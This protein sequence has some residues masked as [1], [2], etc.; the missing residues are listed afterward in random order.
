M[1]VGERWKAIQKFWSKFGLPAYDEGV[2]PDGA[3]LPY[4]TYSAAVASF[5]ESVS[6][7]ASLWYRSTSWAEISKKADEIDEAVGMGGML[8]PYPG[9]AMW[10]TRGPVT[11]AQRMTD[12]DNSIRRILLNLTA[13]FFS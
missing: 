6:M 3:Q 5:D 9:G 1:S 8:V 7:T 10:V 13:E 2:V 12:P 4:L 11:F